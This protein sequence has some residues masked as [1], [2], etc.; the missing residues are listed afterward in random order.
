MLARKLKYCIV[1]ILPALSLFSILSKSY[2]TFSLFAF[3]FGIIPFLELFFRS[4]SSNLDIIQEELCKED[5]F[6]DIL[7]YSLVPIQLGLLYFFLESIKSNSY[8]IFE[9]IGIITAM[10][11]M[12]GILGINLAHEL[13]HRSHSYER[14][15]S[16]IL[17]STSLYMHFYIEHNRGHHNRVATFEDPATSRLNE[18]IYSFFFRSSWGSYWSAWQL[19]N[20]R[21]KKLNIPIWHWK[22][23]MLRFQLIQ[24]FGLICIYYFFGFK[25]MM[26]FILAACIGMLLLEAVNYIE[27]YGLMRSKIGDKYERT[28]PKHSWNSNHPIGRMFLFELSRHSDHHYNTLRKFQILRHHDDSPQMPTGYPGMILLSFVPTLWFKI[29]HPKLNRLSN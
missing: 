27:H 9:S 5:K 7:L 22:N 3:A 11:L 12:C 18:S 13:G 2:W 16:K 24:F 25:A 26:A 1:Y 6:Y 8:S 20:S 29:M 4:D 21:L 14:L 19:E 28:M 17:L 23:E 15:L 10:G